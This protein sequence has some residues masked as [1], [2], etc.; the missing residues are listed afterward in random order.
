MNAIS[1]NE[2]TKTVNV[3][4]GARWVDV[5]D[6]LDRLGR[7]TIGGRLKTIGVPGLT[8]IGGYHYFINKYG[9]T[10]D[11]VVRYEAVL[12]N[13]TKVVASRTS[14]PDLFWGLKGSANN[15]ALVTNFEFST[16]PI[17]RLSTT[18]QTFADDEI[19]DF[20]DA[21]V[22]F[23]KKSD[24]SVGA[25]GIF[26]I[27]LNSSTGLF[28]ASLLGAQEGTS[29][30]PSKFGSFSR[31]NATLRRN[32][33]LRPVE[34]HSQ[35]DTPF[36]AQRIQFV[37]H[38]MKPS[39][40]QLRYLYREWRK[41]VLDIGDVQGL[42]GTF[43]VNLTPKS[44]IAVGKHNGVG[45]LW[46]DALDE[47]DL[48]IWQFATSWAAASDDLRMSAWSETLAARLHAENKA[49]DLAH[50]LLYMGDAGEFQNPFQTFFS[51]NT[52]RRLRRIRKEY[53]PASVFTRNV[54]GGFKM[55]F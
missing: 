8:L 22:D 34:W 11:N 2:R 43:V 28:S 26:T 29:S 30:P 37:S 35:F 16:Y 33:V 51:A 52:L 5:Y 36:Q 9:F 12:G 7:Y 42:Y 4:P 46:E 21:T 15:L 20:L 17:A 24:S 53:D 13:G 18:I 25:G 19:E 45:N 10:M 50:P 49:K 3:A 44:A 27:S 6:S 47:E 41:A 23:L 38:T 55:G 40:T 32:A 39:K 54:W 14:H 1:Y 48:L 31:L